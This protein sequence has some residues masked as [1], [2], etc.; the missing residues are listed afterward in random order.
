[1]THFPR[2]IRRQPDEFHLSGVGR[3]ALDDAAA[4]VRP[5]RHVYLTGIGSGG[6]PG[7]NVAAL[8]Q[9]AAQPV[10]LVDAAEEKT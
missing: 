1:M 3:G 2:D 5:A 7:L 4:A 9:L 8:F 10:Y 6:R